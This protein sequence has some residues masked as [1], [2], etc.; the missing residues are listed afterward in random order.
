M[1]PLVTFCLFIIVLLFAAV[2]KAQTVDDILEKHLA[3]MGGK[4]K[5]LSLKSMRMQGTM[6]VQGADV[7]I[8]IS[9]VQ[10]TGMRTDISVMGTENYV[11]IT[12]TRGISFMPVFGQAAPMEMGAEELKASLPQLD[13]QGAL[14]DYKAK[15]NSVELVGKVTEEGIEAYK[16]KVTLKNGNTSEYFIDAKSNFLFK[17]ISK[18]V[19]ADKK[20]FSTLYSNYKQNADGFWF[21]YSLT[22]VNGTTDFFQ[23]DTNIKVDEKIFN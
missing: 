18:G 1:K 15:G 17:V 2:A 3:A 5:L 16:L 10:N 12:P 13:L 6:S 23:I 9:A 4:D 11:I 22:N 14:T 21:P 8:D 7:N 19:T 20:D